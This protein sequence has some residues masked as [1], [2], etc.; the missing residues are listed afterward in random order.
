MDLGFIFD[1]VITI[2]TSDDEVGEF[3][4]FLSA[5]VEDGKDLAVIYDSEGSAVC[6]EATCGEGCKKG[7]VPEFIGDLEAAVVKVDD[8]CS[9]DLGKLCF[10]NG[11]YLIG[12]AVRYYYI[13]L[14]VKGE[15]FS[16]S[17]LLGFFLKS[18]RKGCSLI[19]E[20]FKLSRDDVVLSSSSSVAVV[21]SI[22]HKGSFVSLE[23]SHLLLEFRSQILA[24]IFHTSGDGVVG[25]YVSHILSKGGHSL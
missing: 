11:V 21:H 19:D 13:F 22:Q 16:R 24:A 3:T 2:G 6:C 9:E 5:L 14:A 1:G 10:S 8:E 12:Y 18:F 20:A 4:E 23:G 25:G 7:I 17:S 15:D